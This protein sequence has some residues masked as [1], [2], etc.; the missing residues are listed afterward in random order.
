MQLS[1]LSSS[2]HPAAM[3]VKECTCIFISTAI[4]I[5]PVP[6]LSFRTWEGNSTYAF[7]LLWLKDVWWPCITKMNL[8]KLHL[9]TVLSRCCIMLLGLQK[10][11]NIL[12]IAAPQLGSDMVLFTCNVQAALSWA[13]T[14]VALVLRESGSWVLVIYMYICRQFLLSYIIYKGDMIAQYSQTRL[15]IPL[16]AQPAA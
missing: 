14:D 15:R 7:E 11:A 12:L 13:L 3:G 4:A 5:L 9:K 16:A 10:S 2:N 1:Y 8:N 6:V